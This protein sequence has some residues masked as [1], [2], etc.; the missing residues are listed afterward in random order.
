M[1]DYPSIRCEWTWETIQLYDVNEH[2]RLSNYMMWMN[3]RD[4]PTIWC[5]WTW[6]TIQLYDVNEHERLS[7]YM[8]RH[9]LK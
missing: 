4:Y 2:E 8:L 7:N 5:E 9:K 3:M 6:E 1:R